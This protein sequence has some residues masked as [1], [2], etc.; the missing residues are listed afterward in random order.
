VR[1]CRIVHGATGEGARVRTELCGPGPRPKVRPAAMAI[2]SIAVGLRGDVLRVAIIQV[3]SSDRNTSH[4][5]YLLY[6]PCFRV[7]IH[8]MEYH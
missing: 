3:P 1:A 7:L 8:A 6:A 5:M 2:G 4:S